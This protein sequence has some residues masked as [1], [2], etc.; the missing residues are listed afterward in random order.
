VQSLVFSYLRK[1]AAIDSVSVV[2]S[3]HP[4]NPSCH[5]EDAL[6]SSTSVA[7]LRLCCVRL[8]FNDRPEL[9]HIR[10][11]RSSPS[12]Y[13]ANNSRSGLPGIFVRHTPLQGFTG[14]GSRHRRSPSGGSAYGIPRKTAAPSFSDWP[15]I[16]PPVIPT[17]G[18]CQPYA[19]Q[20]KSRTENRHF[21]VR[22]SSELLTVVNSHPRSWFN[23]AAE[24]LSLES[25]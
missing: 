10:G 21:V 25:R 18:P 11:N 22:V 20:M 3:L 14:M 7:R 15:W 24:S 23:R 9:R 17:M 4:E 16:C 1:C 6:F 12:V 2:Q 19:L 5:Q 8:Q 13:V